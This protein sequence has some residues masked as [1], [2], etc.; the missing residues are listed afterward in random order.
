MKIIK[1]LILLILLFSL[2]FCNNNTKTE[3]NIP[4]DVTA[5]LD[6]AKTNKQE[7]L[8]VINH[9]NKDSKDSLKLKAAYFLISNMYQ[10]AYYKAKLV[11]TNKTRVDFNV[12]DYPDYKT[13][14]SAW[15]SIE[16]K[17]GTIDY[18][19]DTIIYDLQ[20]VKADYLI[21][22]IDLAFKAWQKPW[23]KFLTFDEFC[24]Y[25]LPYRS[26]NEPVEDWRAKLFK[27]YSWVEDSVKDKTN[28]VEAAIF[29]NNDLKSWYR[30]DSRF[31]R[32]PTDLGL[33]EM[34]KYKMGRCEDMTNL[35][36]YSMRSQGVPVMSDYT[37]AWPNT[38]NN[39][40]WNATLTKDGKVVIFMGGEA[41]P[42]DYKLTNK[43]SKVY[44]KTFAIQKKSLAKI[45]PKYEK[46]PG[47]LAS[48]HYIDVTKDY[49][50]TSNI[51]LKLTAEKPDSIHFAYIC[52]FNSGEWKAIHWSKIFDDNSVDFTDM[53]NDI[54]YL[55]AY[56]KNKKL[57]PATN[58]FIFTKDNK[59]EY[60][61]PDTI[62]T[63]TIK[64]YSTTRRVTVKATDEIEI[65][66]FDEN[67]TYE[68]F[69]WNNKWIKT[70]EQKTI[71]N[72][73]LIFK[74]VPKNALFWLVKKD[75]NK[76]ERIFTITENGKQKWW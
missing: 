36:I 37:P 19:R 51:K 5:M 25:I 27:K 22:N 31:Y 41:N 67:T 69:Y 23:A 54:A 50:P 60:N 74:N 65:A 63:Q 12:L 9:Y 68:L 35:A 53:G 14:V 29:I 28:P 58:Q 57:I 7:L 55:V 3:S 59:I 46:L 8:K 34:M 49:I 47:W 4:D 75:S 20:Y 56:Y 26:S 18:T 1:Q 40:A 61:I 16:K 45:A 76:E 11:D 2:T 21:E 71:N 24:E 73:P 70:G 66:N 30:F 6:S 48:S 72:Q 42:Y 15:D 38:G 13:M 10:Q 64:L 44:R 33:S 32:H 62:N 39:H 52:V 43:K 17:I